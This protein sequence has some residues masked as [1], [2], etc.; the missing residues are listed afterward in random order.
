MYRQGDVLFVKVDKLPKG[1][2]L[3]SDKVLV[4]GES[5][6][7]AH[8][9]EGGEVFRELSKFGRGNFTEMY[10][11]SDGKTRIVHEEHKVIVLPTGIF[12]VVLQ[13]EYTPTEWGTSR[14]LD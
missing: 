13:V 14:I 2:N 9:V 10:V 7:H 3:S 8:K 6:G 11:E 12:R 4:R 5:T 1:F